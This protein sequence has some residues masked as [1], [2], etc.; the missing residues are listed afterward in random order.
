MKLGF[1]RELGPR[2]NSSLGPCGGLFSGN[3]EAG[4]SPSPLAYM[5]DLGMRDPLDTGH[6]LVWPT[7]PWGLLCL[8]A[9]WSLVG[10]LSCGG[11]WACGE[12]AVLR[13]GGGW[14]RGSSLGLIE[15]P[16]DSL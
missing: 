1:V 4:D 15:L 5:W 11:D 16:N 12:P 7:F 10:S 3:V 8:S 14:G 9:F 13:G 6:V 2:S